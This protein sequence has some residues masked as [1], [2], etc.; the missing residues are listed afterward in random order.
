MAV[1]QSKFSPAQSQ[2]CPQNSSS[3]CLPSGTL[4]K[5]SDAARLAGISVELLRYYA[6]TGVV[7][8]QRTLGQHRLIVRD[9]LI[10]A[11]G[12][13]VEDA[14]EDAGTAERV[15]LIYARVSTDKQKQAG[16]L[17][18]QVE[19]LERYAAEHYAGESLLTI[20]ETGS[21]LNHD[22]KGFCRLIDL[23]LDGKAKRVLCEFGDRISRN[24]RSLVYRLCEKM[25]VEIVETRSVD[26]LTEDD[27]EKTESEELAYDVMAVMTCFTARVNGKRGGEVGKFVVSED[28]KTRICA[29]HETGRSYR[30]IC[31]IIQREGHL[32]LNHGR[33]VKEHNIRHILLA[34]QKKSPAKPKPQTIDQFI[35]HNCEQGDPGDPANRVFARPLFLAYLQFCK[36]TKQASLSRV[37]FS[38]AFQSVTG[39]DRQRHSTKRDFYAGI[40]LPACPRSAI[41]HK[42]QP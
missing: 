16:N 1:I 22:R 14:Q 17:A 27:K 4:L 25:G 31:R 11:L 32:D 7:E 24:C 40:K 33:A 15:T 6:N 18:R 37:E 5:M 19:R 13:N 8:C 34:Y 12:L 39:L 26:G 10:R 3:P 36:T 35:L 2:A 29:L 42:A 9:S 30:E 20:A 38:K 21:G 41:T 28:T 23:V